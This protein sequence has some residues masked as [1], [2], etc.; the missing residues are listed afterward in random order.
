MTAKEKISWPEE[1]EV[2]ARPGIARIKGHMVAVDVGDAADIIDISSNENAFGPS[3]GAVA[4]AQRSL[5]NLERY[6]VNGPRDL[7]QAI[8]GAFDLNADW[9]VCGHGSDDLLSRVA[10]AYLAPGDEL[11][12]SRHGYQKIPNYAHAADAIPVAASDRAFRADVGAILEA[13]SPRTRMVMLANPDNPTGTH[14]SGEEVRALHRA[15]PS[16]VLLVLDSAYLEYA[17]APDFEDPA[18]LIH[19][20]QNVVMTRTFSKVFGLASL[21]LGWLYAPPA[22]A[23]VVRKVGATFPISGTATLAGIAALGER[24]RWGFVVSETR[25]LRERFV[26]ELSQLNVTCYPSQTNFVLADFRAA[27][28]SAVETD[29]ALQESGILARRMSAP[30]FADCLRFTIGTEPEMNKVI[31]RLRS[32]LAQ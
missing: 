13:V 12:Y 32:V 2:Q 8:A 11:V 28:L 9:V 18:A 1:T 21:R 24:D 19:D 6:C 25:R 10:R 4:A 22:I 26:A 27:A 7:A 17:D 3:P 20:S 5:A 14:L 29:A 31:A 15:L 23:Q 16:N 30:A